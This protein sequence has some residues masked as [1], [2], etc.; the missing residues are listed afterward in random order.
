METKKTRLSQISN[1]IF[2]I[3]VIFCIFFLWCNY[4]TKNLK[5]TLFSSIIVS[6]ST[7]IILIPVVN[8][9]NKKTKQ[10]TNNLKSLE[11]FEL[12]LLYSKETSLFNFV[13]NVL[14]IKTYSKV[15][16]FHY[17]YNKK[18]L[19]LILD[20]LIDESDFWKIIRD[21]KHED[22]EVVCISKPKL[23]NSIKNLNILFWDLD[24]LKNY[25]E[26]S[27][28]FLDNIEQQKKPKYRLKDILCIVLNKSKAKSYFCFGLILLFSSLFTPFSTY[29]IIF[30]TIFF[31]LSTICRFSTL[32]KLSD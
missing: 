10:K 17:T 16:N 13:K 25:M 28:Q 21:R 2:V 29:Y 5:V 31:V 3:C 19:Y 23:T 14:T 12:R 6:V 30:S 1:I 22:I 18:D 8:F 15:S 24:F 7:L 20:K 9:K 11:N 27:P 32:F 4:Y 26:L